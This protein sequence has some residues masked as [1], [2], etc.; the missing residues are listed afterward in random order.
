MTN[1]SVNMEC[2]RSQSAP[3][4]ETRFGSGPRSSIRPRMN[5]NLT[6]PG[7]HPDPAL[8]RAIPVRF[9]T[10]PAREIRIRAGCLD[11][12]RGI[13]AGPGAGSSDQ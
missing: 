11:T 2:A 9:V 6:G 10:E 7:F 3:R 12:G 8:K 1:E 5:E 13:Q 4:V